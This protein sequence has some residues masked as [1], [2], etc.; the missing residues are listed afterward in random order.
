MNKTERDYIK[1]GVKGL[2]TDILEDCI[3]MGLSTLSFAT[4]MNDKKKF[5]TIG[6]ELFLLHQEL[7]QRGFKV[8][9]E[10]MDGAIKI[11]IVPYIKVDIKRNSTITML[12]PSVDQLINGP[13]QPDLPKHGYLSSSDTIHL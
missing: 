11:N 1:K 8:T 5:I 7:K 9:K 13:I 12:I 6:K 2:P 10:K 3:M 4:M